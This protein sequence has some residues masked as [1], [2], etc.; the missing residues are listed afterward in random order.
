MREAEKYRK[1]KRSILGCA[2]VT[3]GLLLAFVI[4]ITMAGYQSGFQTDLTQQRLFTLTGDSMQKLEELKEPIRIAAVYE[5]GREEPMVK[6]LLAEYERQSETISVSYIDAEKN[7]SSLAEY[8]LG[9]VV[10]VYNGSLIVEGSK[11]TK[12]ISNDDLFS[13]TASG[14]YFY[15]EREITGAIQYVSE[16]DLPVV[17]VTSG[18][19]ELNAGTYLRK[20]TADLTR[21]AYAVKPLVLLQEEIPADAA[22]LVMASPTEDLTETEIGKLEAFME[23]GGSLFLMVDPVLTS[24]EKTLQRL[25]GFVNQY[26]ID[27]SNNY[28]VEENSSYYLTDQN[29]YLIPRY[30]AHEITAPIGN[31]EKMVVLPVARGLGMVDYDETA[32]TLDILLQTSDRSWARN[33]MQNTS[34]NRTQTDLSGPIALGF[35][36]RKNSATNRAVVS[37]LVVLGDSNYLADNSYDMQANSQ[38]FRN[39]VDWL[40]GGRESEIIAGKIMNSEKLVVRGSD[41]K[42]LVVICCVILPMI[43]FAGAFFLWKFRRNG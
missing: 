7:P 30:S 13:Y 25:N 17:Y 29:T 5:N 3:I 10:A 43:C 6:A 8:D 12:I 27:I 22:I 20:A 2:V 23:R 15:G 32:V 14:N 11:R 35:A 21:N 4:L 37:R 28:V 39:S 24:N 9:D 1:K 41:F 42:K 31:Q 16:D 34:S 33:D 38:L 19:G 40:L 36:A 26:G 18:H